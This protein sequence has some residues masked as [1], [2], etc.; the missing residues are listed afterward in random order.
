[1]TTAAIALGVSLI[2][3]L[4]MGVPIAFSIGAA[5]IVGLWI[6]DIPLAL[7]GQQAFTSLDSFPSMA[8]PFFILA[9]ALMETGGLSRRIVNAAQS[10]LG[11]VTGGLAIVTILASAFFAAISGSSPATVAAIGSIMVPSMV[12]RGYHKD[13]SAAVAASGGGLGIIIPPSI[14]MII[15][16]ISANVSIGG[17]FMAGFGPGF[18][19]VTI[20]SLTV[21][22]MAKKRGYSG[23]GEKP[24]FMKVARAFWDAKWALL[25]PVLILGGIYGGIFTP[26]ESAVVAVVYGLFVGIFVYKEMKWKDLPKALIS[27]AIMTGSV[28]IIMSTATAFGQIIAMYQIPNMIAEAIISISQNKY[29]VLSLITVFILIVGTFMETLSIIIILAPL[30][31]PVVTSLGVDP[32]HFGLIMV[33]GAEI[34]MLT[35]PLGV[36]LFVASGISKL[37]LETIAKATIPFLLAMILALAIITFVPS[38]SLF[39]PRLFGF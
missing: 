8:V 15:Y 7:L 25:S 9:G 35:P 21:Y 34:G 27:S 23:S 39:L 6:G 5:T 17:M 28:L 19:I 32:I 18:V 31:L 37:S 30:F 16:G 26:T 38:V 33:V 11:H 29:V 14:P 22:F 12:K 10:L 13:F 20:L 3:F 24:S 36:N 4:F 2:I 1:M